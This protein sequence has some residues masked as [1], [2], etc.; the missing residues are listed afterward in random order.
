M[1]ELLHCQKEKLRLTEMIPSLPNGNIGIKC[2][3]TGDHQIKLNQINRFSLH[4]FVYVVGLKN[5]SY[6]LFSVIV[7]RVHIY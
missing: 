3:S 4:T 7:M 2:G 5:K 1:L 6:N